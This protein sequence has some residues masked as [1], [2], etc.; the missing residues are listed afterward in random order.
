MAEGHTDDDSQYTGRYVYMSTCGSADV[1][2]SVLSSFSIHVYMSTT[3]NQ[4]SILLILHDASMLIKSG[5]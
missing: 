1:N 2:I 5:P 3:K 4:L